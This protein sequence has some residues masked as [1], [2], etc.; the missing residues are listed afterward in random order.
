MGLGVRTNSLQQLGQNFYPAPASML[1]SNSVSAPQI[2]APAQAPRQGGF[3]GVMANVPVGGNTGSP[4]SQYLAQIGNDGMP[5]GGI[6]GGRAVANSPIPAPSGVMQGPAGGQ[7]RSSV[8]AYGSPVP[9]L[10]QQ[11]PTPIALARGGVPRYEMGGMTSNP[12]WEK[13]EA[14][15]ELT[16]NSGLF[17]GSGSGRTDNLPVNVP[18]DS[19]VIPADVVSGLGEGNTQA[20][21]AIIDKMMNSLPY[22]I[23]QDRMGHG[24]G[25]MGRE[26]APYREPAPITP[27][28]PAPQEFAN[29]GS[30]SHTKIIAASGEYLVHPAQVLAL[31]DG[32]M[33]KGH[34]ILDAFIMKIREKTKKELRKLKPPKK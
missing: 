6:G 20:G 27:G 25:R 28:E 13:S 33:A 21:A 10:T 8:P 16:H 24:S 12:W 26:P 34:K 23:K 31:G 19:H 22:G 3:G 29:G 18:V 17:P 7:A 2:A 15:G 4:V 30:P 1:A 14:R 9:N 11:S 5:Q 32:D